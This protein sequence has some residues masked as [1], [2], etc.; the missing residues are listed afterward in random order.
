MALAKKYSSDI[1]FVQVAITDDNI[2][3]HQGLG[4]PSIPFVHLYYPNGGGLVEE[5]KFT[6]KELKSF[7]R[8]LHDHVSGSCSLL[9][10]R[11]IGT[12]DE[13]QQNEIIWSTLNPY[14][15]YVA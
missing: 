3:L 6:R 4:V 10:R 5:R 9:Q 14:E 11:S 2:N 1:H 8:I 15:A 13:Q 12:T 7:Q